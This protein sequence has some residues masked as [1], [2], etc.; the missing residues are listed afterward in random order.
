MSELKI[1]KIYQN[2]SNCQNTKVDISFLICCIYDYGR[3]SV[4]TYYALIKTEMCT[5]ELIV[6]IEW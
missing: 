2:I 6:N 3:E 1:V 4:Y 5:Y